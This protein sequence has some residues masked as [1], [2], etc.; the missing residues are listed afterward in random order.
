MN[1]A[2]GRGPAG[3]SKF[4]RAMIVILSEAAIEKLDSYGLA[5]IDAFLA[6]EF[7]L[8]PTGKLATCLVAVLMSSSGPKGITCNWR[9]PAVLSKLENNRIFQCQN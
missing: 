8:K 5:D 2:E 1:H 9:Y 3:G 4:T 6:R 7:S